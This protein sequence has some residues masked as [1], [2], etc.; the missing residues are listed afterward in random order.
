VTRCPRCHHRLPASGA[1]PQHGPPSR[2]AE[3]ELP[4][5]ALG[6]ISGIV[7]DECLAAGGSAFVFGATTD[8]DESVVVKWS[9]WRDAEAVRRFEREAAMT[10]TARPLAPAVRGSGVVGGRPYLVLERLTGTTIA[11]WLARP[12]PLEPRATLLAI[13]TA[14]AELHELGVVHAD[15]KPENLILDGER[16]RIIDFGLACRGDDVGGEPVSGGTIYYSAPEQLGR[17]PLTTATDI[18]ALGVIAFE[19]FAG[20]PPFVGDRA[21]LEY[22]HQLC[23]PPR[24]GDL[25]TVPIELDRIV[26]ACLSKEPRQRPRAAELAGALAT[27]PRWTS[28]QRAAPAS[29]ARRAERGPALLLWIASGDLATSARIV[30]DTHGRIVRSS[31]TGSMAAY[32]WR[33]HDSPRDAALS[34]A[35]RLIE[36]GASVAMHSA[37]VLVRSNGDRVS[38]YGDALDHPERWLPPVPWTGIVASHAVADELAHVVADED[39][40]P[41]FRRVVDRDRSKPETPTTPELIARG[42][43]VNE[44]IAAVASAMEEARPL[45]V[46][47]VGE[48]RMGKS[49]ALELVRTWLATRSVPVIAIGARSSFARPIV[50]EQLEQALADRGGLTLVD[51]L[52]NAAEAGQAIVID[53]AHL[54]EDD[55]LDAIEI[56]SRWS[57]GRLIAILATGPSLLDGRPAWSTGP[58]QLT[59]TLR[60]L[61]DH[62]AAALTRRLLAPARRVPDAFID[63]IVARTAGNPGAIVG[64]ARELHRRGLVRRHPDSDEWYVAADEIGTLP[65]DFGEHWLAAQELARLPAGMATFLQLC[66]TLGVD[67][68]IDEVDAVQ[69]AVPRIDAPIDARAGLDWLARRRLVVVDGARV[70]IAQ[71]SLRAAFYD[72]LDPTLRDEIHRAAYAYWVRNRERSIEHAIHVAHHGRACGER[73]GAADAF[74]VLAVDAN[75]RRAHVEAERLATMVLDTAAADATR[76]RAA[77]LLERARARRPLTLYE[78]ARTDLIESR[79]LA[80]E[81]GDVVLVIE[82]LVAEGA[83][84][85]FVD[86]LAESVFLIERAAMLAEAGIPI[87]TEARLNNWLGVVRARQDRLEE[88]AARL[89]RAIA[90][91]EPLGDHETVVGSMLMLGGVLRRLG[92]PSDGLAVLD[93]TIERCRTIRDVFH[94]TIGYFNRI[95]MWRELGELA[96]AEA[97]CKEAIA[98]AERHGYGQLEIWGWHNLATLHF[99]VGARDHALAAARRAYEQAHRRFRT[100][101]P[102][103]A[104]LQLAA[105]EA[106]VGASERADELLGQIDR[107]DAEATPSTAA[108]F[109]AARA[110]L[111]D[112]DEQE[113]QRLVERAEQISEAD[114]RSLVLWLCQR[115]GLR[116]VARA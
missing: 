109:D 10:A 96:N 106:G 34:T 71:P 92:R 62:D 36:S 51:R 85:D 99:H 95:N 61:C 104:T 49:R 63:V 76:V 53:D 94:L 59:F 24:L 32:V 37:T 110:L 87:A 28:L 100:Q 50:A 67:F 21:G 111:S 6:E 80:E 93:R 39:T 102:M 112:A 4:D 9:R 11:E 16:V 52:C 40:F 31:R 64:V 69:T 14:V 79:R 19:L 78:A 83:I 22:A 45:L 74:L 115:A 55:V 113:W 44:I 114:D 65:P 29:G 46:T 86:R 68:T 98:I 90:T 5:H 25:A 30:S 18:Y 82:T 108:V 103:V 41:G 60:Q 58:G 48:S 42:G 88:A 107:R 54:V 17:S 77:A 97:D 75:R 43:L 89:D 56:A 20:R 72:Q 70:A 38:V 15:L 3:R 33:E 23:R 84:C 105:F 27:L 26:H 1:C 66:A 2:V 101:P 91:A 81:L 13:A 116:R 73:E 7:Q 47:I 57:R 8:A 35:R 12:E